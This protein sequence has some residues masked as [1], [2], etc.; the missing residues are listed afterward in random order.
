MRNGT[1]SVRASGQTDLPATVTV[2]PNGS[3]GT[4]VARLP[5]VW[6]RACDPVD[7]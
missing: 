2:I 5:E 4:E 1:S 6:N 7:I 3:K